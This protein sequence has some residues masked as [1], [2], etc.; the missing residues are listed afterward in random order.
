M[1]QVMQKL[2][3]LFAGYSLM[4]P[5]SFILIGNFLSMPIVGAQSKIFEGNKDLF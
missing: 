1:L 5:T 3:I 2:Q 4:P